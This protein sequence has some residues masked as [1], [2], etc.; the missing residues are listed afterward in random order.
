MLALGL[1]CMLAG[2]AGSI[3][4]PVFMVSPFMG[5]HAL[6]KAFIIVILGGLG[7]FFGA[8]VGGLLIGFIECFGY[9]YIGGF[10]EVL[11]Y[12]MAILVI[13]LKPRGLFGSALGVEQEE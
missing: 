3:I 1:G 12:F 9:T 7:S 8:V 5:M 6:L 2:L 4:A 10:A 11:S 13:L